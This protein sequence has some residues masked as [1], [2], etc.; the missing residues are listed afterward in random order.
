M[1]LYPE[2]MKTITYSLMGVLVLVVGALIYDRAAVR[3]ADVDEAYT[4]LT[5]DAERTELDGSDLPDRESYIEINAAERRHRRECIG[6]VTRWWANLTDPIPADPRQKPSCLLLHRNQLF[7][8][9][10]EAEV[11][12][13]SSNNPSPHPDGLDEAYEA[14]AAAAAVTD[15]LRTEDVDSLREGFYF[16]NL[17][18]LNTQLEEDRQWLQEDRAAD[19]MEQ[20]YLVYQ[21][22]L[23]QKRLQAWYLARYED[24]A[25]EDLMNTKRW[26]EDQP[27]GCRG[28]PFYLY[29]TET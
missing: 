29:E 7:V 11:N 2:P 27:P 5:L 9:E 14:F 4:C 15:V 13:T 3:Y 25:L 23:A 17:S 1:L 6:P 19:P 16:G 20:Y 12:R 10:M 26:L 22:E 8:R 21:N 18:Y 28:I 24:V